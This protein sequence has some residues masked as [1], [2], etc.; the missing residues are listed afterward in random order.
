MVD[1]TVTAQGS[2]LAEEHRISLLQVPLPSPAFK[3][4]L[5]LLNLPIYIYI[6]CNIISLLPMSLIPFIG[7]H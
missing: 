3:I 2:D 7:K 1:V 6:C 5:E 4:F